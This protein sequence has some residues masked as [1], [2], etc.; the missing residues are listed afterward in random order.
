[1]SLSWTT[2][3]ILETVITHFFFNTARTQRNIWISWETHLNSY[4]VQYYSF[5]KSIFFLKIV[6]HFEIKILTIG[7]WNKWWEVFVIAYRGNKLSWNTLVTLLLYSHILLHIHKELHFCL[8]Y[9]THLYTSTHSYKLISHLGLISHLLHMYNQALL[10]YANM[11]T[12]IKP[13]LGDSTW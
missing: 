2:L 13:Q 6:V 10:A 11:N 9:A 3:Y 1:M 8:F 7:S 12:K 4:F 5:F